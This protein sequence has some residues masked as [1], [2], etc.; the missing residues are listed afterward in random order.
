MDKHLQ[1]PSPYSWTIGFTI[2]LAFL[3][4][5]FPEV[6]HSIQWYL[7]IGLVAIFGIP[8]GASDLMI[9]I[10]LN[11]ERPTIRRQLFFLLGYLMLV[12]W[13][14]LFWMVLPFW[15]LLLF[16]AI[17]GYH[18]G[19]SN[20]VVYEME[21]NPFRFVLYLVWGFAVIMMPIVMDL[22]AAIPVLEVLIGSDHWFIQLLEAK[23]GT[24]AGSLVFTSLGYLLC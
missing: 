11:K 2:G 22:Q 8:H 18:F 7:I 14:I 12:A 19:Q 5:G 23:G 20:F 3:C 1:Q 10:N 24:I 13:F 17:S 4:L 21:G 9:W 15:G 6:I 16:L